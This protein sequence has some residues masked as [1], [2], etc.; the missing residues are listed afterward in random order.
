[1]R[2][3]RSVSVLLAVVL[4][5]L[6]S[7]LALGAEP[8]AG[9]GER[10]LT[11]EEELAA[12]RKFAE[13]E[14]NLALLDASLAAS[15]ESCPAPESAE[16][17]AESTD[18]SAPDASA[19]AACAPPQGFIWVEAR[20]QLKAHYCGP[21]VGQVIA[22]YTWA[23]PAGKNKYSQATI[24]GWMQTD[25]K[26]LTNAPELAYGLNKVTNGSPRKPANWV[27][28][29]I[30]L[31]DRN[32]NGTVGDELQTSIRSNISISK[33]PIAFAVKPHAPGAQ[34]RL[35][36]WPKPVN[37]VGHWIAGYGWRDF[38]DGTDKARVW[39]AD[40]SAGFGGGTGK[41]S[42]PVRHMAILILRHTQRYVW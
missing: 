42:D 34:F 28:V 21:A 27:W 16:A 10:P 23:M 26:G 8:D 1:M 3:H 20:Q 29:V 15:T 38:Y 35:E 12:D 14:R 31:W 5:L 41:Y 19:T 11:P 6:S 17:A 30:Q 18:A 37:S 2:H 39:Y 9:P 13:A 33:M 36:S 7:T 24:A 22:N 25:A 4:I 32:G 40:S